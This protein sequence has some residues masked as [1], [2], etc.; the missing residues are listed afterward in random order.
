MEALKRFFPYFKYLKYVWGRF[1]LGL[2]FGVLFSLSSGLGLP[3]MAETVFPI[4]FG[5]TE[6]APEWLCRIVETYFA[7][8]VSGGFLLLCSFGIPAMILIRVLSGWANGY[9]MNYAGISVVQQLQKD[10]FSKIQ[11]IPFAFFNKN[12]T[13][14][15][16]ASV[17]NYPNEIRRVVVDMSNDIIKQPLTLIAAVSFLIYKSFTSESFSMAF[18]GV[19]T[20]PI[21]IF[22]IRQI[23]K[24]L[25]K[26]SK[27]L[28]AVGETLNSLVIETVQSPLEVRAFNLEK[29]QK[30]RFAQL[31]DTFFTFTIKSVR[32]SLMISPSIEFISSIGFGIALYLGVKNGMQQE[33][34][35]A[36]FIA[37][38][39][40]YGPIKRLG[41]MHGLLRQLEGPLKRLE[42]ILKFE[43][44]SESAAKP[45]AEVKAMPEKVEGAIEFVNV[46]FAYEAELPVFDSLNCTIKK[47]APFALS[48]KSGSGKS[49]LVNLILRFYDP[50]R[51]QILLDGTDV[52]DYDPSALRE[53]IAY[54]PQMPL[55]FHDT[56]MENI[57][58]GNPEASDESV[59]EAAKAANA[60]EFIEKLPESF[61]TVI[62][63]K[64]ST[65]SGG[66][67]QRIAIARAFLKD[68]PI[69]I[70]DEATS[71]LDEENKKIFKES[72]ELLSK[73]KTVI[74][75]AHEESSMLG[76]I[77]LN[78]NG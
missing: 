25:S 77:N 66:Q 19:L 54:V 8:D 61:A 62:G 5:N 60:F 29:R 46:S 33:E 59:I 15:I 9:Y 3:I 17:L 52:R 74:N 4:L 24:Y 64:G 63:E 70:F 73:T 56:I 48:G 58:I 23:A 32:S 47:G 53:Y 40:A 65:L 2:I 43:N 50:T 7:N 16:I 10:V 55:L 39:M 12:Q 68:V 57:R 13:G 49:T 6:N 26:R 75:I 69:M 27:Q 36:L 45:S 30:Q 37:L 71:A 41:Q 38:Y 34:F 78:S 42:H 18:I 11:D 72:I 51:G 67:R 35:F 20:V 22:P 31:L 44:K 76:T 14:E 1:A 28:V 21:L